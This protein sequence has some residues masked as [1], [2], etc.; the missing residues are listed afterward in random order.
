MYSHG[1]KGGCRISL[2]YTYKGM[3]VAFLENEL[4]EVGILVD[5]GADVFQFRYKPKDLDFLWHSPIP[6]RKPFVA[7]SALPDGPFPDYF[8]GGWQDVLTSAGS[9][10]GSAFGTY[11]GPHG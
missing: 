6:M 8:Y 5:K 7:T 3:R 4:L 10:A 1:R 11:H 9:A 2:D